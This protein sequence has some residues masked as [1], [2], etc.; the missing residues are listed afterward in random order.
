MSPYPVE[1]KITGSGFVI[2]SGI[3]TTSV[4]GA[5]AGRNR[6]LDLAYGA[7]YAG[8]PRLIYPGAAGNLTSGLLCGLGITHGVSGET[9]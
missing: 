2:P 3:P 5:V 7:A 8:A 6:L 9:R 1:P 4:R